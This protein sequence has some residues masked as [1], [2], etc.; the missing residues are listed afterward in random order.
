MT[1]EIPKPR[2]TRFPGFPSLPKLPDPSAPLDAL[3]KSIQD[4]QDQGTRAMEAGD[5][6]A[7]T[8]QEGAASLQQAAKTRLKAPRFP[9]KQPPQLP[10]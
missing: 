2:G 7:Q 9:G 1:P 8:A 4:L 10:G 6:L 3:L 5:A